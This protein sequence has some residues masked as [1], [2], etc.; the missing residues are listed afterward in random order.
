VTSAALPSLLHALDRTL[1]EAPGREAV[2]Y[3]DARLSYERFVA[4]VLALC[5]MFEAAGL[6]RGDRVAVLSAARPEALASLVASGLIGATWVG[7]SPRYRRNEQSHI[8]R[9]SGARVL[10]AG[11]VDGARDLGDDLDAHEHELSLPVIRFGTQFWSGDLARTAVAPAGPAVHD[12]WQQR[13]AGFDPALPAVV[14]YTSG[15]TG[16]PKGALL[17]HAGIAFRA[18]TLFEDR[19]PVPRMKQIIDLPINHVGALVNGIGVTWMAGG[20]LFCAERFDPGET[21]R[22]ISTEHIDMLGAVP[23]MLGAIL[24]H[25]SLPSSDLSSL[26]HIVWGAGVLQ[27]ATLEQLMARCDALF[28]TQYGMTESNGPIAYTPPTR[29]ADLLLGTVGRPD[30]RLEFRVVDDSGRVLPQ[31]QEGAIEVRLRYPFLGYLDQPD[32]THE[33]FTPDGFLRTHD[34][35]LLR[36]DGYLVFRGRAKDMYKSGGFNVYPREAEI[37]LEAHPGV[38]AAA[39]VAVDD[40]QWGQVGA[41]FVELRS[42]T[43]PEALLEWCRSQLAN[44]KVP[45]TLEVVPALP[46]LSVE[47]V[48]KRA[49]AERLARP[50]AAG[51]IGADSQ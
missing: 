44:Y 4:H 32:A 43:E 31:G 23:P 2:V 19:F 39:I 42:P 33:A 25:P 48:D 8:L 12:E 28:S 20:T 9:N 35:G 30:P 36:E 34:L 5:R 40:P 18:A 3:A 38:R 15:S 22:L 21:L 11:S 46:R 47:K 50:A 17:S 24:H 27:R 37:V 16:Q 7:L 49:L 29:D 13:L 6:R 45:K 41:A 1:A 14:I 51:T 26:R 10:L